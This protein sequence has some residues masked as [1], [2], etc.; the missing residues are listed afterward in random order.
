VLLGIFLDL[1][2]FLELD[3]MYILF[4]FRYL[5]L[6]NRIEKKIIQRQEIVKRKD[7]KYE[8]KLS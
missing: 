3:N 4:N 2:A 7:R 5:N 1:M 6:I 8:R